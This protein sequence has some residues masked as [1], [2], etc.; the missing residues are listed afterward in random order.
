MKKSF[1]L[2]ET[3]VAVFII[4]V[5]LVAVIALG[6]FSF[7]VSLLIKERATAT[8][9][10]REGL[11]VIRSIRDSNWLVLEENW[12]DWR[13]G[14]C[15]EIQRCLASDCYYV[16]DFDEDKGKP[17]LLL[18]Q[19]NSIEDCTNCQLCLFEGKY[20]VCDR[21]GAQPTPKDIYYRLITIQKI[22]LPTNCGVVFPCDCSPEEETKD[23]CREITSEILWRSRGVDRK[24]RLKTYLTNWR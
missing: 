10:G 20:R 14:G 12:D 21:I 24:I 6:I 5:G 15:E 1:T 13:Q 17:C 11:E 19:G 9:L 22:A 7:S 2:I 16:I 23:N 3:I 4:V 18:A 8:D